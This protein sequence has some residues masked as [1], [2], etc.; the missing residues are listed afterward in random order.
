MCTD[1]EITITAYTPRVDALKRLGAITLQVALKNG[2]DLTLQ[3]WVDCDDRPVDDTLRKAPGT[4]TQRDNFFNPDNNFLDPEPQVCTVFTQGCTD[5]ALPNTQVAVIY[6]APDGTPTVRYVTTDANGC[7]LDLLPTDAAGL[8]ETQAVLE[9]QDCRAEAATPTESVYV[10]TDRFDRSRLLYFARFGP[11]FPLGNFNKVYDPGFSISGGFSYLITPRFSLGG[12]VGFHQF[13]SPVQNQHFV[14]L[15]LN[16]KY[17]LADYGDKVAF[18]QASGGYYRARFGSDAFGFS[19]GMGLAW[20]I[21]SKLALD[22]GLNYHL[23]N[24]SQ[25]EFGR[26]TFLTIP[27]GFIWDF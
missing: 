16:S 10:S 19:V 2:A 21:H 24:L 22:L 7:Y 11:N 14:Q 8:W 27:S 3:S 13:Y 15:A 9:E 25:D 26:A 12:L 20:K 18:L 23:V 1:E 17:I 5:P 6:T 4:S